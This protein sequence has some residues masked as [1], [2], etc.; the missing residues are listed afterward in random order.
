[1]WFKF[2]L[3]SSEQNSWTVIFLVK[4]P[5]MPCGKSHWEFLLDLGSVNTLS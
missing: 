3:H 2:K 4:I 1:M 5:S